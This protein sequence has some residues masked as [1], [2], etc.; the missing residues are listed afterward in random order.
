VNTLYADRLARDGSVQRFVG[1]EPF[2]G[3][4]RQNI[5]KTKRW[6]EKQNLAL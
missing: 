1:P 2:L 6:M 3:V 5:G 4:S